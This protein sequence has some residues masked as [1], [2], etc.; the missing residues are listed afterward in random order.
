MAYRFP[1][2]AALILLL[3]ILAG[4]ISGCEREEGEASAAEKALA[5]MQSRYDELLG[6]EPTDA[7]EWAAEDFENIG[8]W[9]YLV[10]EL[11]GGSPDELQKSLN[12]HGNERWEAFWVEPT[13]GG[14]RV[15]LKRPSRSYLSKLPLSA[16]GKLM[17]DGSAEQ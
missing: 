10:V 13:D 16:I 5:E 6:K 2:S 14:L 7:V 3:T 12:S 17:I 1:K 4:T 9:E 15:L 11:P 8:D